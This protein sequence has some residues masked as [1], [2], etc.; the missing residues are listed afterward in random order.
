[1]IIVQDRSS[2]L[3]ESCHTYK[4]TEH[5]SKNK[6]V[7]TQTQLML[8]TPEFVFKRKPLRHSNEHFCISRAE[9]LRTRGYVVTSG[10]IFLLILDK[11]KNTLEKNCFLSFKDWQSDITELFY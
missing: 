5:L 3:F 8:G 1:V 6:Q 7:N 4:S 9:L 11:N 10:D 2:S